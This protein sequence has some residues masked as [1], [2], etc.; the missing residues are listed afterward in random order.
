MQERTHT[1]FHNALLKY[2]EKNFS[3]I[4]IEIVTTQ[5]E[6][7]KRERYWIKYYNSTN[8]QYGYNLD[9]GGKSGNTKSEETKKKIGITTIDKW[10]N[11]ETA[12]RM[13]YGL[14]KGT[15][16]MK[17]NI[18][19]YPFTC[20]ICHQTFYYPKHI[21]ECKLFCSTNCAAKSGSWIK[22]V[23]ASSIASHEKNIQLKKT[24]K[25]DIEQ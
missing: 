20:P 1:Y 9:S 22:G 5:E 18:K 23:K 21:A 11:P 8:E 24:I 7:D 2:G 19:R 13:R 25:H 3:F 17:K 14:K 12:K 15:E 6:A 16:T 4:P 10:K